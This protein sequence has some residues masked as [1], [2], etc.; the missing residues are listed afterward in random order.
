LVSMLEEI[1]GEA[2]KAIGSRSFVSRDRA[3]EP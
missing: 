3:R 2:T 1:Y